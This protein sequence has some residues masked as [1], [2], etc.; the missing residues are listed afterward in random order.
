MQDL[1]L[2]R[3]RPPPYGRAAPATQNTYMVNNTGDDPPGTTACLAPCE[4]RSGH[5]PAAVPRA[6]T[7]CRQHTYGG[8]LVSTWS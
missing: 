7:M 4:R 3:S 6:A 5:G 1:S 8:D 2:S